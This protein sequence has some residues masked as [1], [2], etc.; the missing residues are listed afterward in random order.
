MSDTESVTLIVAA[1]E[2]D[3]VTVKREIVRVVLG[4]NAGPPGP[5]GSGGGSPVDPARLLPASATDGQTVRRISG[6]WVAHSWPEGGP[7]G[8]TSWG[9]IDGDLGDQADLAE[10]LAG[11]Q[12]ATIVG[13]PIDLTA[14]PG[15]S[16]DVDL[17]G[18][19]ENIGS[20]GVLLAS[21]V[22]Q[23]N[24]LLPTPTSVDRDLV[25]ALFGP[26]LF[27]VSTQIGTI[28][29][30]ARDGCAVE[31][32]TVDIGFGLTW[33]PGDYVRTIPAD[34]VEGL[35][36][37][38]LEDAEGFAAAT[39]QQPAA[40]ISDSTSVGRA[41]LTAAD[42]AAARAAI[43]VGTGGG[44]L[45]LPRR[46]GKWHALGGA[47]TNAAIGILT[48]SGRLVAHP[49]WLAAGSYDRLAIF[50]TAA[51]ASTWRLGIYPAD[52]TTLLP[53]GQALLLDAGTLDMSTGTG[54]QAIT[55]TLTIPTTGLYWL[56]TLIDAYTSNPTVTGW[57]GNTGATPNLP[58]LGHTAIG[59][60]GGR[61]EWARV[62]TGVTTGA[63]P[64]TF[65]TSGFQADQ[66]A[67]ILVRA[68]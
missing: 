50:V 55:V 28:V 27:S 64:A 47:E 9:D 23:V 39:H 13:E 22:E 65:P 32:R 57:N 45:V 59:N 24:L 36:T 54:V 53:D 49:V 56:A 1:A 48:A 5:P 25:A 67:Q 66:A 21:T 42:A 38:A 51:Q 44:G 34:L 58:W 15:P 33:A 30:G 41:V 7:G 18:I 14:D 8:A 60:P 17:T 31:L 3:A 2:S 63:M 37:A 26:T 12:T 61:G 11:K 29:N 10:A 68:T 4:P 43:D 46:S 52:S 6:A 35:G 19:A 40:S 16:I 62:V 20:Q